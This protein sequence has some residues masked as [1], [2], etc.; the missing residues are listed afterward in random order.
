FARRRLAQLVDSNSLASAGSSMTRVQ[1]ID[2]RMVTLHSLAHALLDELS[3]TAGYPAAS[4]R[5]RVY[6]DDGQAGILIYTATADSAG[7]LGGLASLSEPDRLSAILASAIRRA[8]WCTTDPVCIET[9]SSGV[10][11]MNLA[12]CH[13]C[14]LLPETSCEHFN[15]LLDRALLVG[16]LTDPTIGLFGASI[17]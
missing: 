2:I 9:T 15:L 5:E 13:A 7:S 16:E 12:A 17:D 4:L 6:A 14:L 1:G 3:L 10:D 11:G 8:R